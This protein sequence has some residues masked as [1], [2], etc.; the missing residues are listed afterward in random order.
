MRITSVTLRNCRL[1]RELR[2]EFDPARTLIGGP[3]ETG[4]ST[5][6]EAVHRA[7]FLKA[8][9]NTEQHRA[10]ISSLHPGQPEVELSFDADGQTY[11]LKKRF[12]AAGTTTLAS[13]NSVGLSGEAAESE[14][15]RLLG[16]EAGLTGKTVSVQWAHLWVWQ[17]QAGDNPSAHAMAQQDG[18][19]RRLQHL[20]GAAALQSEL[21]VR[22][23]KYFADARGQIYTQSDKPKAG[24]ELERAERVFVVAQDGLVR[25]N[26]RVARLD[27]AVADLE[28]AS[29]TLAASAAS[30]AE[31]EKQQA[32][33]EAKAQQ[34]VKLRQQEAE[35]SPA[36]NAAANRHQ[37]LEAANWQILGIRVEISGLAESL[38]P[39]NEATQQLE[40]ASQDAK[41]KATAAETAHTLA[42]GG[43]REARLRNDLA[44]AHAVLFEKT[45]IH[46]KLSEKK[47]KASLH[48]RDLAQLEDQ[49]AKL[50]KVDKA[51]LKKIQ[52]LEAECS[53]A[54]T[55]LQAMATGLEVI[56]A[57]QP[58]EA[59]GLVIKVGERQILTEDTD[60]KIGTSIRL[61]IRP[62]GGNSLTD[63]RQTE[64]EAQKALLDVL[65]SL[66][67][68]SV[69]EALEIQLNREELGSRVSSAK[70]ELD[71]MG[72]ENLAEELQGAQNDLT[73][74]L[75]S[76]DRL[77]ALAKDLKVPEDKTSAKALVKA[78]EGKLSDAEERETEARTARDRSAK[79]LISAE[80]AWQEKRAETEAQRLK[81]NGLN[82]QLEL[83]L[84]THGD[85]T[86]RNRSL[87]ECQA[88]SSAAQI[89]LKATANAI[90]AL[91]PE[92]LE[93]DRTR[94]ARAI[95]ARTN[96]Q[97]EAGK[98]IAVARA[99]LNSDG[100]E[101]PVADLA[102]AAAK[103]RSAGEH[104]A[105][106]LRK[107]QATALLDQM[108]HEEQHSLAQQFT[109]P[110]ADKI[111]GYLQCIFGAGARAQVEL[112]NS[113]FSGLR[114]A[115]PGFGGAP[116][117]FDSLS[118]GAK[119][120]TAAAVRLAMAEVLAADHDGCLPVFF[121]DAFAYSDPERVSR[122]QRMLD[123][124]ATRGLQVIVLSC[125]PAD[126]TSLGAKT[127]S[128]HT[129]IHGASLRSNPVTEGEAESADAIPVDAEDHPKISAHSVAVTDE[130]RQKLLS[131]LSNRGG[132]RGNQSLR[133]EL[134]WED[135][136]YSAVKNDLVGG[137]K[138]VLGR[139]RGGSVS[140]P[141]L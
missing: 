31:L 52:R 126:Y 64:A 3:N 80:E 42:S 16:V 28:G 141:N 108:F 94:L 130:L 32:E 45:E 30:L 22:V 75:A 13:S 121:D 111:S 11:V 55:A 20:G 53:N 74:A 123:L 24:S 37:A 129:K 46:T 131:A 27:S 101:D 25:A 98:N 132:S 7:M 88:M 12:G 72:V 65:D 90:V 105:S 17:G 19:L 125:N 48:L 6:I 73:A 54:R 127:V 63:A 8:K 36:A 38:K 112:E 44:S 57:E 61:R 81:L 95:K 93:G 115:R 71:G 84:K 82:A 139:G 70:A 138:L 39:Q 103:A 33:T 117:A 113:E 87:T 1:H 109:Q 14:L 47:K 69:N 4:K 83:L 51:K 114:L 79:A 58:V 124:A 2:V 85:D 104:R 116:F 140:L 35:Q 40:K 136:T 106:L 26:E 50:P 100:S 56:A 34:L 5:L 118:G 137:G 128:L 66:G 120:Q 60:V 10:M 91:Q 9:G 133:E 78:L 18:L 102:N 122:L 67:I 97:H 41:D 59:G 135:A 21:D 92:L 15:A 110:L 43:V 49:L 68:Q 29:R 134:G 77:T 119:E 62:G 76:V 99:A 96:E 89:E 86:A 107:S 23:A